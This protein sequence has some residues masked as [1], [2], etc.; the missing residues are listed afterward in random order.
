[1]ALLAEEIVEE[2]LNRAGYFTARGVKIGVHEIDLLAIRP[3]PSGLECRHIEVQASVRPVSYVTRVPKEIQLSTGRAPGSA[4]VRSDEELRQGIHEW[5]QKKFDHPS[6]QM[7]RERLAPGQQWS[8]ELV[9]NRVKSEREAELIEEAGI[10]V[11]RLAS[12]L[13]DLQ[14]PGLIEGAA[15]AH[16]VDLVSM[17]AESIE[18]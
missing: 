18:G 6:K 4:K 11:H 14:L 3:L 12:I 2:W 10:T 9:L 7:A 8:R 13:K 1:M 16:L 5:I 15:G 17:T